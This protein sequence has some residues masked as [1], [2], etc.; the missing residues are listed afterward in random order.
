MKQS[1]LQYL[2]GRRMTQFL[3]DVRISHKIWGGFG[4]VLFLLGVISILTMIS[5][6]GVRKTISEV[7][8]VR[9]PTALLS[10][11]LSRELQRTAQSFGF[12]LLSKEDIYKG[13]YQV[14]PHGHY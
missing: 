9:Q 12:Y 5:L 1:Y 4:L 7:V 6:G 14:V 2:E 13:G 3:K 11:E 10:I 8:E